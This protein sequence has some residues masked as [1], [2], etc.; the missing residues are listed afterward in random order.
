MEI[1]E[2]LDKYG[3]NG[4]E[5]PI[6]IGSAL[7]ALEVGIKASAMRWVFIINLKICYYS[8]KCGLCS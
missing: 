8:L 1:R 3:F 2:V 4:D 6:V 7:C 5:T